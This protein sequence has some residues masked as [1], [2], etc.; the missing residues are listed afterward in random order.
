METN[1]QEP[2]RVTVGAK[3]FEAAGLVLLSLATVATAQ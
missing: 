1:S 2:E 3:L